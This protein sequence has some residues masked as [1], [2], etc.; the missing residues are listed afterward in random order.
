MRPHKI[1]AVAIKFAIV[2]A[3]R[4]LMEFAG[5][6]KSARC[7]FEGWTWQERTGQI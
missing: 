3:N 7:G 6:D 2:V 5:V 1:C 4:N